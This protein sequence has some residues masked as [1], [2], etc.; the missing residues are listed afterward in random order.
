METQINAQAKTPATEQKVK[1]WADM[2]AFVD[3]LTDEQLSMKL[4]WWGED[5]AGVIT[6]LSVLPEDYVQVDEYCEAVSRL[7]L[8]ED[9]SMED[10]PVCY[11]KGQPIIDID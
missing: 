2:K 6:A 9:E 3:S 1:T 10:Y 11:A 8:D 7:E 5:S 4:S